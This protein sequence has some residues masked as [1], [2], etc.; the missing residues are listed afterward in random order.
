MRDPATGQWTMQLTVRVR[1]WHPGYWLMLL[2]CF[3]RIRFQ[4]HV[5]R[6]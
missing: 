6:R 2:R 1:R 4:I 5:G 3:S